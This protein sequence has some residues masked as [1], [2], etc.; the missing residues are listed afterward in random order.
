MD[1]ITIELY[2]LPSG[3]EPYTEWKSRLN[4]DVLVIV[5]S[6]LARLRGGN[7]GDCKSVGN[8]VCELKIPCGPGYRIYYGKKGKSI[9][10]L[11]CAG[12]KSTQ[13]KDIKKAQEYWEDCSAKKQRGKNE[14]IQKLQRRSFQRS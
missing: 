14:K 11:L 5:S 1:S 3:K 4:K 12:D 13:K 6:R 8:G 9:V 10:I 7:F 2:S